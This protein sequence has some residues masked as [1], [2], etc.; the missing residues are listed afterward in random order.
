MEY[1]GAQKKFHEYFIIVL[2]KRMFF[3]DFARYGVI[4]DRN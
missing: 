1:K 2:L 3:T 4:E